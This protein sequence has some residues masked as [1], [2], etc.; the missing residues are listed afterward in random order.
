MSSRHLVIA[1]F[2]I[3]YSYKQFFKAFPHLDRDGDEPAADIEE[4]YERAAGKPISIIADGMNGQYVFVGR[5]MKI[6]DVEDGESLNR[7]ALLDR[8][9]VLTDP[10]FVEA[11]TR[12]GIDAKEMVEQGRHYAFSHF[13]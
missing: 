4:L 6:E 11:F 10:T 13:C 2:G 7:Y 12:L 9:T 3:M 8:Q 1:G 5:I